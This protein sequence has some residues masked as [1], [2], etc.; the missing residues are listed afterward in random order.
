MKTLSYEL[1]QSTSYKMKH[2][3]VLLNACY[4]GALTNRNYYKL[5]RTHELLGYPQA[6]LLNRQSMV[7]AAS[8]TIVDRY[9]ALFNV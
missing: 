2:K 5:F 4:S 6:F 1:L 8:W 3:L 7:I 9:N